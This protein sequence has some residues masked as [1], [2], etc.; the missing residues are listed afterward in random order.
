[1]K[2]LIQV[3]SLI[4]LLTIV[5]VSPLWSGTS[6]KIAG[7][8]TD[9]KTGEP[10]PGANIIIVETT[11]GTTTDLE[12]QYTILE[13][14]PGTYQMQ[15]SYIGYRKV[16][17]K[18][19]IV[20]ID[21][22]TR[23]DIEMEE[24]TIEVGE[25]VIIAE[26]NLI[27]KDVA[28]SVVSITNLE[29]ESLPIVSIT[30]ALGLQAGIRGGG[31]AS[32]QTMAN[33]PS[34]VRN[35][36][37]GNVSVQSDINIRG[38]DGST[39][40][41]MQDGI[42]L[43][44]PR[45][46]DP[47][48]KIPLTAVKEVSVERGGFTAEYGQVRSGVVNIITKEG[49]KSGYSG[50]FQIRYS[51]PA[52]KYWRGTGI[53]DINDP[54]SFALRPFYDPAVC[55]TGTENG[56]WDIYTKSEYPSFVGW[57]EVA[58]ILNT[59][60]NPNNDLTPLGAQ[61]VFAYETRKKQINNEPDFDIDAGFGGPI[62]LIGPMLGDLRFFASYRSTREMLL[63]PLSRPDYRDY[64]IN[65][66]VISDIS[67]SMKLRLTALAGKQYT[68]RANFDA[69]GT[70]FYPRYPRDVASFAN[71][72]G[73]IPGNLISLYSDYNLPLSDIEHRSISGKFIHT[74][75]ANSFY[76]VSVENF[77]REY[78]TRPVGLRDT[79]QLFE[80]VPGYYATSNPNGYYP[81][82]VDP[83]GILVNGGQHVA[84]ARDFSIVSSTTVKADFT[85]QLNFQNLV[86]AGVEFIYHDLDF[87]YGT[88]SSGGQAEEKYQSRVQMRVFPVRGG[89]YIQDKLE[90]EEFTVNAGVRLDYSNSNVEWWNLH[91]YDKSFFSS[92]FSDT[93]S[94]PKMESI[95]QWD[96]SPRLGIA[97]PITENAKLFFNYGHFL[98]VPQYESMFRVERD[99]SS[100]VT[101]FGNPNLILART[102]SYE[103]GF[104]YIIDEN[105]LIQVAG[106]YNDITDQQ[107]FTSYRSLSSG[108][109]YTWSTSNNYQDIRGFEVTLRKTTGSWF[110]GFAN[111]TYQVTTTGHFGSAQN[112]DDKTEQK[113][114]DEATVNLYQDRPQPQPYARVNLN[115]RSPEDFGPQLF[116]NHIFGEIG[117]NVVLDWQSGF[118]TTWNPGNLTNI[119]YNVDSRD[120]FNAYLRLDKTFDVGSFKIQLFM[121]VNNVFNRLNLYN[122]NDFDYMTSLHLPRSDVYPNIPGDDKVGDYRE[123]GVDFQPMESVSRLE[124][125]VPA[126]RERAWFYVNSEGK[127]FEWINSQ[128]AEV[129]QGRLDK[130]LE[131]KAYINMPSASTFW[132][133]DPRQIF[134]G[135]KFSFNLN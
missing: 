116:S 22:T 107:D 87:D 108:F 65:L 62:P 28:T 23:I 74:L 30:S 29:L 135:L 132:F 20:K 54:Y 110:T 64:D 71:Y 82:N 76:E 39:I 35:Y 86:K 88:I 10:L 129:D 26:R 73:G 80:I 1:M 42:A 32:F 69:T 47:I 19:I 61:R 123:P 41:V 83:T 95:E 9:K 12:G 60:N 48:A 127:Y 31:L 94:F 98:Q 102:I 115:F 55:W 68:M 6:G 109:A 89:A 104:D 133:L 125:T 103:L 37:R 66:Q 124:P 130:V 40:L 49:K 114:Y 38:G 51:P 43:R 117:L 91:P 21:Q 111:F 77:R 84:R 15:I 81:W 4:L 44:D 113:N 63:F 56:S 7:I 33:Q 90:F 24:E 5:S 25:V 16:I 17:V 53:K 121:D 92:N 122:T 120:F 14:P 100:S 50:A 52:P 79:T 72:G 8:V 18:D 58:R 46:N 118:K 101:S 36:R 106:F 105:Y 119:A 27:K 97:H 57:N 67:P 99:I 78:F 70:Y 3:I 112:F 13:V 85:T 2:Q 34:F 126:G 11:L 134:F 75:N 131:D 96:V 59:D 128:W 93:T 45:N